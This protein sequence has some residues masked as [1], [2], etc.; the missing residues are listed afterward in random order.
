MRYLTDRKRATGLGSAHSGTDH[1]WSM[2]VNSA[3][4][5]VLIM[6]FVFTFGHALGMPYEEA[7]AYYARTF[8]ALTAL[9][10]MIV[11]LYHF[12]I[13]IPMVIEDYSHGLTRKLLLIGS[14]LLSYLLM[15][16]AAFAIIRIAL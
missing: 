10:T 16:V 15:G 4:L 14:A 13:G 5:L 3:A 2:M 1:H 12:K 11:G 6:F 7:R 8:P 9:L